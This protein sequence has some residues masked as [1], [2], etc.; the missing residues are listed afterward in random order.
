MSQMNHEKV[1]KDFNDGTINKSLWMIF[2]DND[3]G[4]WHYIGANISDERK[5]QMTKHM[6]KKYGEPGGYED[7]VSLANAAGI[8][9]EWV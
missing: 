6:E 8:P 7:I 2:W 3:G 9:S 4:Y 5:D 1:V